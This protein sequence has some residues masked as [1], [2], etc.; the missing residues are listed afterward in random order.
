MWCGVPTEDFRV[1]KRT[2]RLPALGITVCAASV[3][4]SLSSKWDRSHH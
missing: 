1:S 3:A 4:A 2:E